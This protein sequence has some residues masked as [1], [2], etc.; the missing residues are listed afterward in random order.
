MPGPAPSVYSPFSRCG[1]P[2]RTRP[3]RGRAGCRPWRRRWSCRARGRASASLSL[4]RGDQLE[5]LHQHAG[6]ALRV[7]GGPG[8][9]RGL[10]VL[11]GGAHLGLRGQRHAGGDLAGHRPEDVAELARGALDLLAADEVIKLR[12]HGRSFPSRS[13]FRLASGSTTGRSTNRAGPC[14]PADATDM[15]SRRIKPTSILN[16]YNECLFQ[17]AQDGELA[18]HSQIKAVRQVQAFGLPGWRRCRAAALR[19]R[20]HRNRWNSQ[21]PAPRP[22]P[23]TR[24]PPRSAAGSSLPDWF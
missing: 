19:H 5:E 15:N 2:R 3:P 21:P 4:S 7:G 13:G 22:S 11:D 17:R 10:G 12:C 24:L 18:C 8:R 16:G 9:L 1:A 14:A 20:S 23:A 6:A